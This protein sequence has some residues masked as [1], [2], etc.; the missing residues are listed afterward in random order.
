MHCEAGK[1]NVVMVK[2]VS[3]LTTFNKN[4]GLFSKNIMNFAVLDIKLCY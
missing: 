4:P 3:I 1:H 2:F